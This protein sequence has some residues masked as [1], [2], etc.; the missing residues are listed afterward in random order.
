MTSTRTALHEALTQSDADVAAGRLI[1]AA[2]VI[3][4][5]RER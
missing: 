1:D 2:E 5:S 4:T 3:K